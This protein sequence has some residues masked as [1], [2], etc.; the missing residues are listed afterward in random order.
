MCFLTANHLTHCQIHQCIDWS[1]ISNR[2]RIITFELLNAAS[3]WVTPTFLTGQ[4]NCQVISVFT[5]T[6]SQSFLLN[7]H[8]PVVHFLIGVQSST[9]NIEWNRMYIWLWSVIFSGPLYNTA[10]KLPDL[11]TCCTNFCMTKSSLIAPSRSCLTLDRREDTLNSL[12][13]SSAALCRDR[14]PASQPP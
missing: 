5:V 13:T 12:L 14:R 7:L 10:E 6:L 11:C 4:V 1:W 2:R 9:T 3:F 8:A